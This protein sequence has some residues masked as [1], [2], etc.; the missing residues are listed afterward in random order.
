MRKSQRRKR[1]KLIKKRTTI[2]DWLSDPGAM[3]AEDNDVDSSGTPP[4]E[5]QPT[6]NDEVE[7]ILRELEW[8]TSARAPTQR[9]HLNIVDSQVEKQKEHVVAKEREPSR[10]SH[11]DHGCA[12]RGVDLTHT[13]S[14]KATAQHESGAGS[15]G[16]SA[17]R[18][19]PSTEQRHNRD[20]PT[21]RKDYSIHSPRR[22][23]Q[24]EKR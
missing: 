14:D 16:R 15:N 17:S 18:G 5:L 20:G 21:Q 24:R 23:P 12:R 11:H 4:L 8:N 13:K 2:F 6:W 19:D 1:R 9:V 3:D 10:R 7:V 22:L